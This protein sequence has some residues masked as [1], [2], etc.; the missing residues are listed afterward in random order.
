[1]QQAFW[2]NLPGA[3]NPMWRS[4]FTNDLKDAQYL[5]FDN[6]TCTLPEVGNDLSMWNLHEDLGDT[7]FV[8]TLT[9][10]RKHPCALSA[11]CGQGDGYGS[12]CR[13][14]VISTDKSVPLPRLSDPGQSQESERE[15]QDS[16]LKV[17]QTIE[18]PVGV[19]V[20]ALCE[21]F[22]EVVPQLAEDK[23]WHP[24][25]EFC[26]AHTGSR[27]FNAA[28]DGPGKSIF[29]ASI[30]RG[31]WYVFVP[32]SEDTVPCRVVHLKEGC[33]MLLSGDM[34]V[35]W[36][37]IVLNID[38][39]TENRR[40]QAPAQIINEKVE[41]VRITATVHIGQCSEEEL[42][43]FST[44]PDEVQDALTILPKPDTS[45]TVL[46]PSKRA[47][48]GTTTPGT[49]TVPHSGGN[50]WHTEKAV[51]PPIGHFQPTESVHR[52]GNQYARITP[53]S[54]VT[55]YDE[56]N[57]AYEAHIVSV[58]TYKTSDGYQRVLLV[59]RRPLCFDHHTSSWVVNGPWEDITKVG[60][61]VVTHTNSIH[62]PTHVPIPDTRYS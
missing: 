33:A 42:Q 49:M 32:P 12:Y 36:Q 2:A 18:D 53:K 9:H 22:K 47:R 7:K 26:S 40:R 28:G 55:Y 8:E 29:I 60:A 57:A 54:V 15:K 58:G 50:L 16:V 6:G 27:R 13:R 23:M 56:S 34:R 17:A 14:L 44:K 39:G 43:V 38:E 51:G 45:H 10:L 31:A 21:V 11:N 25:I 24:S 3:N 46:K 4:S 48:T 41:L 5:V 37:F 62:T 30:K 52:K 59:R 1:M 61:T 20:R 35:R 19:A